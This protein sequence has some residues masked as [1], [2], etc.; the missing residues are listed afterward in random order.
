MEGKK[1]GKK[2]GSMDRWI[3][4]HRQIEEKSEP[5]FL[6]VLMF[7]SFGAKG[8]GTRKRARRR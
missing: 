1:E 2:E 6:C 3:H 8:Q 4:R 5:C 7:C